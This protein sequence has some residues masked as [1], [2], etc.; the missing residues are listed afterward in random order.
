[1]DRL[2]YNDLLSWKREARRKPVLID[3]A[4]QTGK[5]HLIEQIFGVRQFRKVH[6]LDRSGRVTPYKGVFDRGS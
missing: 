3:G 1:M 5:T 6:K 4:R 2:L